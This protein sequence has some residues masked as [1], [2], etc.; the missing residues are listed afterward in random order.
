ME[1][2]RRESPEAKSFHRASIRQL[3]RHV[4]YRLI[5]YD[6]AK[7]PM[8]L[9]FWMP[10][11]AMEQRWKSKPEVVVV[12]PN[13]HMVGPNTSLLSGACG[14]PAKVRGSLLIRIP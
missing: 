9:E 4:S 14:L 8:A 2:V 6:F 11:E 13:Q 10:C 7:Q 1:A 3:R 12:Q 5:A